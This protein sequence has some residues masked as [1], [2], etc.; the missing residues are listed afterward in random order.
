MTG[1]VQLSTAAPGDAIT[2]RMVSVVI[3][4][5]STPIVFDDIT[6]TA[7]YQCNPGDNVVITVA[8]TNVIGTSPVSPPMPFTVPLPP[9]TSVPATPSVL[10]CTFTT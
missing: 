6:G 1:L 2:H 8:D 10:G 9:P 5:S 7:T 4:Q 3:N